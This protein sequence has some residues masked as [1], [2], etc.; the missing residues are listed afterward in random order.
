MNYRSS[1]AQKLRDP[2]WQKKRLEVMQANEFCCEI[3][4]DSKSTLNVHHKQY[5]KGYEPWDYHIEQLA[6][7]C[8]HCHSEH[9][10]FPDFL[11]FACSFLPIDGKNNRDEVAVLIMG[12]LQKPIPKDA[13]DYEKMIYAIGKFIGEYGITTVYKCTKEIQNG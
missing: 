8:E 2:R 7:I 5:L 12:I 3:C 13:A 9:H 10:N 6:C 11:S 1:Y 4:G